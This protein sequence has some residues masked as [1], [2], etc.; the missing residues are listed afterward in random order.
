MERIAV[1]LTTNSSGV[2]TAF[3]RVVKGLVHSIQYAKDD[4]A[5]GVDFTITGETTAQQIWVESDVNASKTVAP[6][7]PTHDAVGVASLYAGSGEPVER[8]IAIAEERIKIAIAS[9][10]DTKNGT[11]H[12]LIDGS[13]QGKDSTAT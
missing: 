12:I 10:G 6:S 9:G 5:N 4:F 3:T 2:A 8:P 1:T 7:L 11:F 13:V